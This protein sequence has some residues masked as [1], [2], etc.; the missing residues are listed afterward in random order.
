MSQVVIVRIY[1]ESGSRGGSL[2]R[3]RAA[4]PP[5][6]DVFACTVLNEQES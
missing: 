2:R 1:I 6:L 5:H 3:Y 4:N